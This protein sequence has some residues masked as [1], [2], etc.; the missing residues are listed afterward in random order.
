[1]AFRSSANAHAA[2]DS[3]SITA[4]PAGVAV[5]DIL[6]AWYSSDGVATVTQTGWTQLSIADNTL[7]NQTTRLFRRVATGT[8]NFTFSGDF[9]NG[10]N[11]VVAA[12][13]GRNTSTPESTTSIITIDNVGRATGFGATVTGITASQGDDICIFKQLDVDAVGT[14]GSWSQVT[15]YTEQQDVVGNSNFTTGT[16]LDTRDNVNAGATGN[17]STTLTISAG[18]TAWSAV[19][20]A[21]KAAAAADTL[22]GQACL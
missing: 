13:S 16:A 9:G 4:T 10:H 11:L 17:F 21:V 14:T 19:V 22:M 6:Y 8:D 5:N 2:S 12:F 7:D 1:M 3:T 20:V 15:N 18:S